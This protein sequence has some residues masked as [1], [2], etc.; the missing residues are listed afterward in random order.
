MSRAETLT[1]LRQHK[2]EWQRRFGVTHL[3][4]F[5]SRA[6]EQSRGDSDADFLVAFHDWSIV[7]DDLVP[8]RSAL[9]AVLAASQGEVKEPRS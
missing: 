5:G 4:W 7:R 6:R 9:A 2:A 1:L 8:L 3:A